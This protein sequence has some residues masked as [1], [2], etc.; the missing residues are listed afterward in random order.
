MSIVATAWRSAARTEA[1]KVR[2]RNEDA[3]LDRPQQG[4]WVVADGMGGHQNGALASRLV[5]DSLAELPESVGLDQRLA[6]L[7][8]CLH[9][10]NR[11]LGQTLTVT[12]AHPDPV[13]GSTV[14]ALLASGARA[15][16]VWAGD[17]RC[18]LW[19]AGR[20][21]QLSRDHSLLQELID[22]QQLT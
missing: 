12:A 13:I 2:A 21:Y 1:G 20:L 4:L 11:R 7:R 5:V 18:Y 8:Q 22:A 14:V 17:S 15:A 19:R 9:E 3:V 10:L 6:Q 16:C